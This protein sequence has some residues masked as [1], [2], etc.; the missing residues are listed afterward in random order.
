MKGHVTRDHDAR[1]GYSG[2]RFEGGSAITDA[3]L[4]AAFDAGAEQLA[5]QTKTWIAPA[6]TAD[7]GWLVSDLSESNAGGSTIVDFRL[8]PG[9]YTLDGE[10]LQNPTAY[11]YSDQPHA[12]APELEENMPLPL[13]KPTI[14]EI[15]ALRGEERW[16]AVYID[17]QI[18]G[19]QGVEDSELDEVA[20][21]SAPATRL[22][23]SPKV[24]VLPDVP[25]NCSAARDHVLTTVSGA[26]GSFS[27]PSPRIHSDGRLQVRLGVPPVND[28]LCAPAQAMGYFGRLNH[29]IK[30]KLSTPDTF[31]WN[32]ANGAGLFRATL[33]DDVTVRL[34][35]PFDDSAAFPI[36]G[37]IVELCAWGTELAN[38]EK[39]AV[40]LG[41]FHAIETGYNPTSE[42]L[43]LA[44]PVEADLRGW[45]DARVAAGD[46]PYLFL[47]FWQPAATPMATGTPIGLDIPL[48]DTGVLLDFHHSGLAADQ[49]TFSLRV[50]ANDTV[51]P[52]RMLEPGGQPPTDMRRSVDLLATIHWSIVGGDVVGHLHDCRRR[53]RPLWHSSCCTFTVG[54][55]H[56]THGDFDDIQFAIDALP[57]EGGKICVLPGHHQG[58]GIL[59]G[60]QNVTIEGCKGF[61]HVHALD[62][63]TPIFLAEDNTT[64]TFKDLTLHDARALAIAGARNTSLTLTGIETIGR[65]SAISL[66]RTTGL[67]ITHCRFLALAE[68][69]AIRATDYPRLRP[70]VL[71]GGTSLD[72]SHNVVRVE[73][74]GLTLQSL[75]GLQVTSRSAHV[76]IAGNVIT[77]G[78]GHGITFGN[79]I[80]ISVRGLFFRFLA[81]LR[82]VAQHMSVSFEQNAAWSGTSRKAALQGADLVSGITPANED[83][84]LQ[85]QAI[86]SARFDLLENRLELSHVA[87]QGC[88][89]IDPTPTQPEPPD[90][91]PDWD[92][93]FISG[94]VS[95]IHV[96]DNE[97]S[98]MGGSGISIPSWNLATRA[99]IGENLVTDLAVERNHIAT[100]ARV[101]VAT[102]MPSAELQQLGFGG[103]ALEVVKGAKIAENVIEDIG[104][105]VRSPTVGI[106]LKDTE[107]ALMNDNLLRN[108]GRV[109][110]RTNPNIQGVSGGIVVD[111]ATPQVGPPIVTEAAFFVGGESFLDRDATSAL[112]HG[113][114]IPSNVPSS[115]PRGASL[116]LNNNAVAVNFG[117]SLDVRGKGT[118]YVADN[119][120]VSIASRGNNLRPRLGLNVS[121]VNT[122]VP[123]IELLAL[124]VAYFNAADVDYIGDNFIKALIGRIVALIAKFL[125]SKELGVVKFENN[126]AKLEN[127]TTSYDAFASHAIVGPYVVQVGEN[128]FKSLHQD[129]GGFF[130]LFATGFASLQCMSNFLGASP[131]EGVS[132]AAITI[133]L[134]NST[135][136]NHATQPIDILLVHTSNLA[137]G[138]NWTP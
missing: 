44:A 68:L 55:G 110:T 4:N 10:I 85:L 66:P 121:V 62:D 126:T 46:S 27:L 18:M 73:D 90:D 26:N 77:G 138:G 130:N 49:W 88:I 115:L 131:Q 75:G 19:V 22:L 82:L 67:F 96:V 23:S 128:S 40:A 24:R 2:T 109:E 136:L 37:Q 118:L 133:G 48:A 84:R 108:I 81:G 76:R 29:T 32:H 87:T 107:A 134:V 92:L 122:E 60:R 127:F 124:L 41:R 102:T 5:H 132:G 33:D 86:Q 137:S 65:G 89:G 54:D 69:A 83:E 74:Q 45:Y 43:T 30:V 64:L 80:H 101:A 7:N 63:D 91:A 8:E 31:V 17:N 57:H 34:V 21:R 117:P 100:C 114:T 47:R 98:N 35:T 36:S 119:H 50:N 116:R 97:I 95:H 12:R 58:G 53:I 105:D 125:E 120:L 99:S 79:L 13:V 16:D 129:A 15:A 104:L 1:Q 70:L 14:D 51:F 38:R 71:I 42:T 113:I 61:S 106:Y 93:Y 6:G 11:A 111:N 3:D 52:K 103:I 9:H 135:Y 112:S 72:F 25:G 94:G 20:M 28:N 123:G 39:T 59:R 78:V 56:A